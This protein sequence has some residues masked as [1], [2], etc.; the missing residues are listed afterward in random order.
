MVTLLHAILLPALLMLH[1]TCSCQSGS[2]GTMHCGRARL[3]RHFKPISRLLLLFRWL[4]A[5]HQM[6]K[7]LSMRTR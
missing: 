1:V 6:I 7:R 3:K 5:A 2:E 4:G